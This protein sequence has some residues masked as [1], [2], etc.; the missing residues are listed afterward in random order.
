[1]AAPMLRGRL[2]RGLLFASMRKTV[3][4]ATRLLLLG[5]LVMGVGTAAATDVG[6]ACRTYRVALQSARAA[7][8]NGKRDAALAA[9]QQA[10]SLLAECRREEARNTSLV[11]TAP[12]VVRRS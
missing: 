1:M 5:S 10:K 4:L 2:V 8:A 12:A 11:A 3:R 6:E 7:L 9:L